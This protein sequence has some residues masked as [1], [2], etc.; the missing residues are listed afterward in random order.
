MRRLLEHAQRAALTVLVYWCL[1]SLALRGCTGVARV[2]GAALLMAHVIK[3]ACIGRAA[4]WPAWTDVAALLLAPILW[5]ES[6]A[7]AAHRAIAC[8]IL[9]GHARR[10]AFGGDRYYEVL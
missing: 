10:M 1:A 9:V 7:S 4:S 2:I 6:A 8:A 3:D 5:R